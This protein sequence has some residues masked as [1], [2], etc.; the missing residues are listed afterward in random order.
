[1]LS[2]QFFKRRLPG[3]IAAFLDFIISAFIFRSFASVLSLLG[4][5]E[6][7]SGIPCPA[8]ELLASLLMVGIFAALG[9]YKTNSSFIASVSMKVPII[10]LA[11]LYLISFTYISLE[12]EGISE[13]PQFLLKLFIITILYAS[14]MA[15]G[16]FITHLC[17]TYM[18]RLGWFSHRV[19]LIFHRAPD[20]PF[21]K[22]IIRYIDVNN[23]TLE[24]YCSSHKAESEQ[25]SSI[26]YLG[27]FV[28]AADVIR[29]KNIDEVIILNHPQK[30]KKIENILSDINTDEVLVRL[31]PDTLEAYSD[32]RY[33]A[34]LSNLQ[35]I[36][37]RPKT[38]SWWFKL[39]KR[40]LDLLIGIPGLIFTVIISP[41]IAFLI[42][43]SSEGP[44]IY[45]QERLGTNKK[46][47]TI[48]KFRTM[49]ID[50]EK[51]GPQ[52]TAAVND[53][54]I[55]TIGHFL[56]RSHIDELPQFWNVTKGEMSIVGPRPERA[57]F[58]KQ[59]EKITP[60]YNIICRAKPGLTSLGMVKYGYAHNLKE[61]SERVIYDLI[62]VNNQSLLTDTKIIIE[63]VVY[64]I[65]KI[66]LKT[67]PTEK[68]N[69]NL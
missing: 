33:G 51:D 27:D 60:Y 2:T 59:L 68:K 41:I 18:L 66:F 11:I 35:T 7:F 67:L 6:L 64:I 42:K 53:E 54:R 23:F 44:V 10:I 19:L 58:A 38:R 20:T 48:Y 63:T 57:Y 26:N 1:M 16:R 29:Q 4:I 40:C 39:L 24:G 25:L 28:Q 62:Y 49:Y 34:N 31:T 36:S 37:I 3:I 13:F 9:S 55:T 43:R 46:P 32:N 45:K 17:L 61:M 47:F 30:T 12:G 56:R 8:P 69:H 65:K 50:S 22:E 14:L 5:R 21:L 15:L 52:I